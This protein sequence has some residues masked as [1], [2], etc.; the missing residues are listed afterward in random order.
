MD[1]LEWLVRKLKRYIRVVR[2]PL[3]IFS[4]LAFIFWLFSI[5]QQISEAYVRLRYNS[6]LLSSAGEEVKYLVDT[7]G[8]KIVE[9]EPFSAA[10]TP[11]L[12]NGVPLR[13]ETPVV[14]LLG[15]VCAN[16]C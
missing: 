1:E 9:M 3:L 16:I 8:C 11:F 5:N 14:H 10:V 13:C 12:R 6:S 2:K 4:I 7:P 15:E